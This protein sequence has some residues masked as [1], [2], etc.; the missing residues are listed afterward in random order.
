[1][2]P[3]ETQAVNLVGFFRTLPAWE[4]SNFREG[5]SGG[6]VI[7]IVSTYQRCD[8]KI[9][10]NKSSWV[11]HRRLSWHQKWMLKKNT[12]VCNYPRPNKKENMCT[13][14]FKGTSRNGLF[15]TL[16]LT[17][18]MGHTLWAP[19]MGPLKPWAGPRLRS[20]ERKP[21]V[22]WGS[23]EQLLFFTED[24]TILEGEDFDFWSHPP[25]N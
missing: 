14:T 6:V 18:T 9:L 16:A 3:N 1:V 11:I 4:A 21:W 8:R 7:L 25:R 23:M 10:N 13:L 5:F 17:G 24:N 19:G 2:K 22:T 12:N 15:E 20:T